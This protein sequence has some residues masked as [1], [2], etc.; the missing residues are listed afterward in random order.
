[1]EES[2]GIRDYR[3]VIVWQQAME[4][5][6]SIYAVTKGWPKEEACG[7]TSQIRRAGVSV[8]A[9]IAEGQG[10][11]STKEFLRHI[12]VARG[13]LFEVETH[14]LLAQRPGYLDAETAEKLLAI[15]ARVSRLIT[16]L[17]R[18]LQTSTNHHSPTTTHQPPTIFR[19]VNDADTRAD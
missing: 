3:D 10:R 19:E 16:G 4:L 14:T 15:A 13:S 18:S 9:N 8:P 6:E 2:K 7:L 5:A 12:S 11:A 1:M 17:T